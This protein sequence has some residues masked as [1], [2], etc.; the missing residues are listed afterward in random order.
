MRASG[1]LSVSKMN[2]SQLGSSK[3]GFKGEEDL[4]GGLKAIFKLEGGLANDSGNGKA[5]NT[6]NQPSGNAASAQNGAQGLDFQRYSYVGVTGGFGEVHLGR[7]YIMSFEHGQGSV[8]VFG[9]NGPAD[10]TN[11]FYKLGSG[12]PATNMSNMVTYLT[13]NM[14]GLTG[15]LQLFMGENTQGGAANLPDAGSGYSAY[16]DYTAGP[17]FITGALSLQKAASTATDGDYT[18]G[19]LGASYDFGIAKLVYTYSHEEAA[20]STSTPKNDTNL[21]GVA[22][23]MGAATIKASYIH[24]ALSMGDGS[25]DVTGDL[26]GLGVDYALSKRTKVY[27]TYAYVKNADGGKAF[28]TG[29]DGGVADGSSANLAVGIYHKF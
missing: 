18:V 10:A 27:A 15:G 22:Y 9:T 14:G 7:E 4:G 24:A 28:S 19:A 21:I 6:N 8:D 23:P 13:P 5:S 2:N 29:L 12:K 16:I 17:L 20:R 1:D 26:F 25:A 3:L 11:M